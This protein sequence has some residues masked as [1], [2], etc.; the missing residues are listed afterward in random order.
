MSIRKR[1]GSVHTIRLGI[2]PFAKLG[3]QLG[4]VE[5]V[6]SRSSLLLASDPQIGP[7]NRAT[8]SGD[9]S[10]QEPSRIIELRRM[11]HLKLHA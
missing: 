4:V 1:F 11:Y 9:V 10:F 7:G 2:E 5:R 6:P 3:G 8:V